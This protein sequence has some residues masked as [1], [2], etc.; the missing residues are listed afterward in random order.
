MVAVHQVICVFLSTGLSAIAVGLG[1]KLPNLRESSPAKI[2]AGFGGTLTLILSAIFVLGTVIPPAFPAYLMYAG[3]D[4]GWLRQLIAEAAPRWF[5][6]GLGVSF[7]LTVI[8]VYLPL[9]MG[10]LAFTKL[11]PQ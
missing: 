11:E 8:A 5:A 7:V 2:A 10:F 1:A 6:I 9:R 4:S 3:S